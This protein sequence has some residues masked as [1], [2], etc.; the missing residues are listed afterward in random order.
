VEATQLLD[1]TVTKNVCVPIHACG[2]LMADSRGREG[3]QLT[4]RT[5]PYLWDYL[6]PA[7]A[8]VATAGR[9]HGLS[10]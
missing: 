10:A 7:A 2:K 6:G 4:L 8:D 3:N 1:P 5:D 9:S